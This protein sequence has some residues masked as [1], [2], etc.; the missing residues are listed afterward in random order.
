MALSKLSVFHKVTIINFI[1][2]ASLSLL[3]SINPIQPP[4][5]VLM[6]LIQQNSRAISRDWSP[7]LRIQ[8]RK[9]SSSSLHTLTHSHK[10]SSS[11][12]RTEGIKQKKRFMPMKT[13]INCALEAVVSSCRADWVR[14]NRRDFVVVVSRA[15]R[16]SLRQE[17]RQGLFSRILIRSFVY[18][19]ERRDCLLWGKCA[20]RKPPTTHNNNNFATQRWI[21]GFKQESYKF[22][23]LSQTQAV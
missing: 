13:T 23:A 12:S 14:S 21:F 2:S 17:T 10:S 8:Q 6:H 18:C 3:I 9:T 15:T 22:R 16:D 11:T 5:F 20:W 1:Q 19:I 4:N 7:M